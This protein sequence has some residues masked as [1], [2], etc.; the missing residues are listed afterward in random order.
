MELERIPFS[1]QQCLHDS[2]KTFAAAAS[3]KGLEMRRML[4]PDIPHVLVGDPIRLRQVLLNLIGNA[5]K[6]TERGWIAVETEMQTAD[7]QSVMLHFT[8]A[9][10]G[11]GRG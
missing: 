5:V 1:I 8:V 10:S 2:S 7:D 4:A 9:D 6:F 11:P 3:Q